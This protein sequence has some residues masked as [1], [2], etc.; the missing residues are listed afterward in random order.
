MTTILSKT[1]ERD[2]METFDNVIALYSTLQDGRDSL[3]LKRA[4]V[5]ADGEIEAIAL[6]FLID[7]E[8]KSQRTLPGIEYQIFKRMLQAGNG[9]LVSTDAKLALGRVYTEFGLGVEGAY[10]KLFFKE[11][12][13]QDFQAMR[14][15]NNGTS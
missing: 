5:K 4:E 15:T 14:G 7:V 1:Q 9:S 13:K 10:R 6:D 11:K 3:R 12:I 8:L 2:Y